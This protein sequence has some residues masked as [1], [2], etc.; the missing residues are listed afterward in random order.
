LY[1]PVASLVHTVRVAPRKLFRR[2]TRPRTPPPRS[3]E[4]PSRPPRGVRTASAPV[5]IP[6]VFMRS[7]RVGDTKAWSAGAKSVLNRTKV[8]LDG[9]TGRC[10][11]T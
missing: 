6:A 7:I 8:V 3:K 2:P 4:R 5:Q 11:D 10:T 1:A 9:N